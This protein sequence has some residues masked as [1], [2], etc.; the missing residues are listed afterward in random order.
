VDASIPLNTFQPQP[1]DPS[2]AY[3]LAEAITE[4]RQRNQ[5]QQR[6]NALRT[7]LGQPGAIDPATGSPTPNTLAKALAIDPSTG[8]KLQQNSLTMMSERAQLQNAQLKRHGLIQEMIDPVRDSALNAYDDV[9]KKGGSA[10]EA[11]AAGQ[12]ALDDGLAPIRNGGQLSDAEKAQL[13]TKFDYLP[14]KSA[15]LSYKDRATLERQD[16]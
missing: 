4:Y 7:L 2:R 16:A 5:E 1:F 6:Q 11:N 14:M 8:L 13:R 3:Q 10:E 15:A 12:K 9:L